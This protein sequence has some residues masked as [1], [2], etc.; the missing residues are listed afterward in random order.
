MRREWRP[1]CLGSLEDFTA[2]AGQLTS[3]PDIAALS[4]VTPW[5]NGEVSRDDFIDWARAQNLSFPIYFDE[6]G[7][8]SSEF[9]IRAY[10][11]A[12][13]LDRDGAVV[14]KTVEGELKTKF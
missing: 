6:S 9:G 14:L 5:R 7:T 11:A 8:L 2:L 4:I 13:Y 12:V 10:P 3:S 1:L